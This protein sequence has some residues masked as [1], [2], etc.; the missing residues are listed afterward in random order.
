[1]EINELMP[2]EPKLAATII[3]LRERVREF[4][5]K[6]DCDFEVFMAKRHANNKFLGKHHVFPGGGIAEQDISKESLMRVSGL[7][8]NLLENYTGICEHP[9][10]LW[11]IA[12]RELFEE[13]GVLIATEESGSLF[14]LND[15][16]IENFRRYQENL[17][18]K[19]D[20]MTDILAKE[21]LYYAADELKYFGR[22]IT[23][24]LS[25]IRFDTHFFLC[26]LP[27]K[28]NINL[29]TTELQEGSWG[30]PKHLLELYKKKQI[31]MIFPQY[32]ALRRLRK[33]RTIHEAFNNSKSMFRKIRL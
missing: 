3:L 5:A 28:Q 4:D 17:Q 14:T 21:N 2:V 15:D 6:D 8:N 9:S 20:I 25:P 11:I 18:E 23:P 19:R 29:C 12:I 33:F 31:K 30:S 7:D 16:N 32:S 13:T 27:L 26:K 22:L 1:L 24:A 10:C